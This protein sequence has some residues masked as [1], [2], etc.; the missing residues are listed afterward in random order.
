VAEVLTRNTENGNKG[1]RSKFIPPA[2]WGV[3]KDYPEVAKWMNDNLVP[4]RAAE[5]REALDY[6]F[7]MDEKK[8]SHKDISMYLKKGFD[9]VFSDPVMSG[10]IR[11]TGEFNV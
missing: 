8:F 7:D 3:S 1:E 4:D 11:K 2:L 10:T 6:C 9:S 5:F